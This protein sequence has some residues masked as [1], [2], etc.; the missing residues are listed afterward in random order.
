M[1][2]TYRRAFRA[3]TASIAVVLPYDW[4]RRNTINNRDILEIREATDGRLEIRPSG[5]ET[6][7]AGD[8]RT[9]GSVIVRGYWKGSRML[10]S[11]PVAASR[12]SAR[13]LYAQSVH[14]RFP[15]ARTK[16]HLL[17]KMAD[18]FADNFQ[19]RVA[20]VVGAGDG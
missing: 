18:A 16:P 19:R 10:V 13:M 5:K 14:E 12:S 7:S 4:V 6:V 8:P 17:D 3:G 11:V 1:R 2:A 20:A 15:L 9:G